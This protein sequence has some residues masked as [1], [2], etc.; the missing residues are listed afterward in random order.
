MTPHVIFN[1]YPDSLGGTLQ[2]I[3]DLLEGDLAGCFDGMYILPSLF[4]SDLDR[5]FGI[6]DYGLNEEYAS[7]QDLKRLR[8]SGITLMLDLVL[9]HRSSSSKEFRDVLEHG[10][11]SRYYTDFI[12]WNEFWQDKGTLNEDGVI[13]PDDGYLNAMFFRKPGLPVLSV[14]MPDGTRIPFW[15]TFYQETH[16]DESGKPR[17][18]AQLDVDITSPHVLHSLDDTIRILAEY[19]ARIIRLDA[20]A[21]ASKVPGKRNFLNEPETWD[22]LS[23][24]KQTADRYGVI[25][26]PEIHASYAEGTR[27]SLADRGY[28]VYDFFLPGLMLQ[29]TETHDPSLLIR[30]ADEVKARQ[31]R[32]VNMLGCHDGIPLL[33][34]RGL[35]DEAEIQKLITV[36]VSRGGYV[37]D[38]YGE[39]KMY[40]QVNTTW[41]SALGEDER[42]LLF[43]RAVQLFM[44]G[45]PQIWYLDLFTGKN[46]YAQ[47]AKEGHK[48]INRTNLTKGEIREK[49]HTPVVQ[50]QISLLRF[51]NSHPAFGEGS[52]VSFEAHG[53]EA[54]FRWQ[55]GDDYAVLHADF[56]TFTRTIEH[57]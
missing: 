42:K 55:N 26:L 53:P 44:P 20:F 49:L 19:G 18:L 51:R 57:S 38:L 30:W 39:K 9:N 7:P 27:F 5:G 29:S 31:I 56:S 37:K 8:D 41:F 32:T 21:Y 48:G 6:V 10:R 24:L 25:L 4:H 47:M 52:T 54:V 45:I 46:D 40:Y 35:L 36:L 15:N 33:D 50:E 22:I 14:D 43:T 34:L 11:Q 13:V 3:A 17:Y 23:R 1:C 28:P 2:D 16:T 12:N